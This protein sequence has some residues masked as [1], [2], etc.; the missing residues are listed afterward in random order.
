MLGRRRTVADATCRRAGRCRRPALSQRPRAG[1]DGRA[2][3]TDVTEASGIDARA[4]A[5]EWRPATT[6]TTAS[7]TST[8]RNFGP[9]QLWRNR[10]DGTFEDAP[11]EAAG[12]D[13]GGAC[14][15]FVDFDGDGWLDLDRRQLPRLRVRRD[16]PACRARRARLL[17]AA[18]LPAGADRLFRNRGDGTF[19]DVSRAAGHRGEAR[20]R[21]RRR[22]APTSTATAASTS[23]SPTTACPTT[24]GSTG[25]RHLRR[26]GDARRLR[27]RRRRASPRRAWASTPATST[28]TATTTSSS[29]TSRDETNTLYV[30]D[31]DGVF[32]DAPPSAGLADAELAPHRLRHRLLRLRQRRMARPAGGERRGGAPVGAD[33]A[34]RSVPAGRAQPALPQPAATAR[35]EDVTARAGRR[36]RSP[37]SG[38]APPSATSTTTATPTS[39]SPTTA[40]P[41]ACSRTATARPKANAPRP[42]VRRGRALGSSHRTASATPWARWRASRWM[43]VVWCGARRA[44]AATRRRAI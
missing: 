20:Q 44:M 22:R 30:N 23:S 9:N 40:A 24:S 42:R 11:R 27:P 25:R 3:F 7:S 41:C 10:G 21:P 37:R 43:A 35:F 36:S 5:W 31:G 18:R 29:P 2:A 13:R 39:W 38:A 16:K 17:P 26:R 34:P 4:T 33:R 19:E 32:H 12:G 14:R 6:T 15:R 8:S 28:A 1:R